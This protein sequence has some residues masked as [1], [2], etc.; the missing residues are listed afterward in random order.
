MIGVYFWYST[1]QPQKISN[2]LIALQDVSPTIIKTK[3]PRSASFGVPHLDGQ[4]VVS[5]PTPSDCLS[6]EVL[7]IGED[8]HPTLEADK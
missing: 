7:V 1:H 6:C 4:M 5:P 8:G 3:I 2:L